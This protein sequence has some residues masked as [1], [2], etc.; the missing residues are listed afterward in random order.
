MKLGRKAPVPG[1]AVIAPAS[2]TPSGCGCPS[3]RT[4]NI[5]ENGRTECGA[6]PGHGKILGLAAN[7]G[8]VQAV[9]DAVDVL[10]LGAGAASEGVFLTTPGGCSKKSFVLWGACPQP[11]RPT[12]PGWQGVG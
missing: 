4:Q 2:Q 12:S 6:L 10:Q 9:K 11:A 5:P 1:P 7:A 3:G 8:L